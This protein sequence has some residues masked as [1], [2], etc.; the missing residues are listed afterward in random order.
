MTSSNNN[1]INEKDI[2]SDK[3]EIDL[4]D[5]VR[6]FLNGKRLIIALTFFTSL[7]T[8]VNSF[9]VKPI[10]KG[11]FEILIESTSD[12]PSKFDK[13]NP[14]LSALSG[15]SL[16]GTSNSN[17]TQKYIL[18]SPSVLKPVFEY[19]KENN[20][21]NGIDNTKFSYQK[22][23][24]KNIKVAFKEK[25]DVLEFSYQDSNKEFILEILNKISK[26]Y[27]NYSKRDTEQKINE[28]II[29]LTKV[30][31]EYK[32]K[33][34][35]STKK[36]NEFSI[37]NGLG[38][39]DGF[40]DLNNKSSISPTSLLDSSLDDNL[41]I[42]KLNFQP[43][44]NAGLRY[45]NQFSLLEKYE[46]QYTDL[47][48]K[49]KPNS[50]LLKS[51]KIKID[52]LKK[53]LKRPNEILIEFRELEKK[54]QRDS[55]I[56]NNLEEELI[57][58]KLTKAK[59]KNPW[60]LITKPFI[61][62]N[63]IYPN[64]K[65]ILFGSLLGS[66][67]ASLVILMIKKYIRGEMITKNDFLLNL[68]FEYLDTIYSNNINL[69]QRQLNSKINQFNSDKKDKKDLGLIFLSKKNIDND[70]FYKSLFKDKKDILK[71]NI[72]SL[73]SIEGC[74]SLVLLVEANGCYEKD[75]IFINKFLGTIEN[76]VIGW[77]FI[78]RK[79]FS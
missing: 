35:I 74:Q 57:N 72:N 44:K 43:K 39:I 64:K 51:I 19:V 70:D 6:V 17:I 40:V 36:F 69:S 61:Y 25:S 5:L 66:F 68:N 60:K 50:T 32:E 48:S 73:D 59:Q 18:T 26:Q 16:V 23:I 54:A 41:V 13:D 2:I 1:L 15:G 3:R 11:S 4:K 52:N 65:L 56:F 45:S 47:S 55:S 28:R 30:K 8:T 67:F 77:V 63:K 10:W 79:S 20:K 53:S 42:D 27:Q 38:D 21:R 12:N 75:C 7:T 31:N 58:A 78:D 29:Y 71:A 9:F 33:A 34:L 62:D 22:W 14:L 49:L 24:K 37:N 46:S 76:K